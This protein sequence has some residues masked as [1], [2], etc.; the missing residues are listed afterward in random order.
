MSINRIR[1]SV[2]LSL[3]LGILVLGCNL[4]DT[5]DNG[6]SL[7]PVKS[8]ELTIDKS[9]REELIDQLQ[10]FAKE[11]D[12]EIDIADYNTNGELVQVWMAGDGIQIVASYNRKELDKASLN[13]Y[14][15]GDPVDEETLDE[16]VTDLKNLIS[17][18]PNVTITEVK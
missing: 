11:H 17:E 6:Y 16:L 3:C 15:P 4:L 2:T 14:D 18:I 12:F 1:L 10:K 8:F 5:V 7:Q 13:F 9:Q